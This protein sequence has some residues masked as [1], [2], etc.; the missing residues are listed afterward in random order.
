MERRH[1]LRNI[2]LGA[3]GMVLL[4]AASKSKYNNLPAYSYGTIK[5]LEDAKNEEG[6][7]ALRIAIKGREE[8]KIVPVNGVIKI[9]GAN[10]E[11]SR[12]LFFASKDDEYNDKSLKYSI[13]STHD[14]TKVVTLWLSGATEKTSISISHN[15]ENLTFSLKDLVTNKEA[16]AENKDRIV[17]A[18][19]L[20]YKEIGMI[21]PAEVNIKNEK[22]NYSFVVMADPQGGETP[23]KPSSP[24]GDGLQTRRKIHNAFIEESMALVN[25]LKKNHAF[26]IVVGDIVDGWGEKEDYSVM[27]DFLNRINIPTLYEAGNHELVLNPSP[28]FGP[29]YD[30]SAFNNYFAA[31]KKINGMEKLLFSFNLGRWHFIVWPDPLRSYFWETHP[32]YFD[33][34]ERDLEKHKDSPCFVFQHVPIH[35]IG[36]SPFNGFYCE[37]NHIKNKLANLYAKYGNVKYVL[38]G[39]VHIPVKASFKTCMEYKGVKYINLP[40]TGYRPR[41]FGE[42]DFYGRP[43]QGVAVVDIKEENASIKYIGVTEDTYPYPEKMPVFDDKKHPAW[44]SEKHEITAKDDFRNG[45]FEDG[46][47]HWGREYIHHEDEK[48]SNLVEIRKVYGGNSLHSLYLYSRRR[49]YAAPGQDRLPQDINQ[50]F[51]AINITKGQK[52]VIL[53][54]YLIDGN[55]SDLEGWNGGFLRVEG[56]QGSI[57]TMEI[58]YSLNKAYASTSK[59]LR[60]VDVQMALNH[61]PDKWHNARLNIAEDF[62]KYAKGTNWKN[63]GV[64]K[65]VVSLG[66]WNINDGNP[67]PIGVYFDEFNL[68]LKPEP[69]TINGEAV[70]EMP[71]DM[72]WWQGKNLKR[73]SYGGEHRYHMEDF[74]R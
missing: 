41:A 9:K 34:L 36:I 40:A 65:I 59:K 23:D 53:F 43:P 21:D 45:S 37:N 74:D 30:M 57:R 16:R 17:K 42:E 51:Q 5:S 44:F 50:V 46:L 4:P 26:N 6:H 66:T 33:W 27:N 32:H 22:N 64:D 28:T 12:T 54:N 48:P 62:D 19:I 39:H 47:K 60:H 31:Q 24:T 67:Q 13:V 1:F 25:R 56:F 58:F 15:E 8:L 18:N 61:E 7:I 14:K 38:S 29:G 68:S 70:H 52:P 11:R 2:G 63:A 20:L 35:P 49:D 55:V 72:R 73:T 69:S 71:V 10:V 3:S